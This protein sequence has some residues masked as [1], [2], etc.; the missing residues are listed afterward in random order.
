MNERPDT[1]VQYVEQRTEQIER[2]LAHLEACSSLG[3]KIEK[4][5]KTLEQELARIKV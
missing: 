1:P 2:L 3:K 4:E 5:I